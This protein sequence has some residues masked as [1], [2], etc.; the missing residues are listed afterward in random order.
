LNSYSDDVR[1]VNSVNIDALNPD[2]FVRRR[3]AATSPFAAKFVTILP[4]D[5]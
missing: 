1:Q 2:P 3:F 4:F 5:R